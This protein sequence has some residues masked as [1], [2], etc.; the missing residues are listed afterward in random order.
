MSTL[1]PQISSLPESENTDTWASFISQLPVSRSSH[2]YFT[3]VSELLVSRLIATPLSYDD[4]LVSAMSS[5]L[6]APASTSEAADLKQL[7]S[8]SILGKLPRNR[9][10]PYRNA[11]TRLAAQP[12][13]A[14]ASTGVSERST[15]ILELLDA[16]Q[17]WVPRTKSDDM[18][19]RSLDLLV[20]TPDAMRPFVPAL[21]EWLQDCNWPP[22]RPCRAQLARFPELALEPIRA[23]LRDSDDG[24]WKHHLLWF[25]V[26]CMPGRVR[27]RA[28]L[29]VERIAQRPQQD[30]IDNDAH[31]AARECLEEM[32]HWADRAKIVNKRL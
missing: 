4:P 19:I 3:G 1:P 5:V 24:E 8:F 20:Q 28:R 31:E 16:S 30:E 14:E 27:Q 9:L 7:I 22:W 29:E 6:S 23:V 12:T 26:E 25:L 17:A 2:S 11:L 10:E 13:E 32:D 15:S 21:L 18:A